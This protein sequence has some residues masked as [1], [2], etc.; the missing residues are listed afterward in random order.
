[1]LPGP[2]IT[3]DRNL[4]KSKI[5][6]TVDFTLDITSQNATLGAVNPQ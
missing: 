4:N 3:K 5:D 6:I 2:K 1:M